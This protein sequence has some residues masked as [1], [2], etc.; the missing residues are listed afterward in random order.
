[1]KEDNANIYDED[2]PAARE[3]ARNYAGNLAGI[4]IIMAKKIISGTHGINQDTVI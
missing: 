3:Y 4:L 2:L 1:M